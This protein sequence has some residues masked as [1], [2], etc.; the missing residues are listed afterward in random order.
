[1]AEKT[2]AEAVVRQLPEEYDEKDAGSDP[3]SSLPTVKVS[4]G[5]MPDAE[6]HHSIAEKSDV[7]DPNAALRGKLGYGP[8][9]QDSEA[10]DPAVWVDV[11]LAKSQKAA[12]KKVRDD[13]K[14]ASDRAEAR[15]K[16]IEK[17]EAD[18]YPNG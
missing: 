10:K 15:A 8:G 14:R 3:L 7:F 17:G 12:A 9:L 16:A 18:P 5:D 2:E 6:A 11:D 1:M 4:K 13:A